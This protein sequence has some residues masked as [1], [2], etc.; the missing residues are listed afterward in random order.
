MPPKRKVKSDNDSASDSA[1]KKQRTAGPK[2]PKSKA[3]KTRA[4]TK[5]SAADK[6]LQAHLA[7]IQTELDNWARDHAVESLP[8][9]KEF[10]LD[11]RD[12]LLRALGEYCTKADDGWKALVDSLPPGSVEKL[13]QALAVVV[14]AKDVF[15][16]VVQNPLALAEGT[17]LEGR[18]VTWEKT[19]LENELYAHIMR[20]ALA[21]YAISKAGAAAASANLWESAMERLS[22]LCNDSSPLR[23]LLKPAKKDKEE[24]RFE[25]LKVA[26]EEAGAVSFALWNKDNETHTRFRTEVVGD[27]DD[28]DDKKMPF[29]TQP[30]VIRVAD[31]KGKAAGEVISWAQGLKAEADG[32]EE[33]A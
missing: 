23:H 13:P 15:K 29:V 17:I 2:A 31:V 18:R 25:E 26:Y 11:A 9:D 33:E 21:P 3:H 8:G 30:A 5:V 14:L 19:R 6:K 12:A 22:P 16:N 20:K 4:T 24:A 10:P 1:A 32:G 27:E 7:T 28:G